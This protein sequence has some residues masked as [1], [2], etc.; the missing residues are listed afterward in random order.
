MAFGIGGVRPVGLPL[1]LSGFRDEFDDCFE[2][3]GIGGMRPVGHPL[4]LNGFRDVSLAEA[5]T[6]V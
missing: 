4:V 5:D 6:F 1:V 2:A 3:L